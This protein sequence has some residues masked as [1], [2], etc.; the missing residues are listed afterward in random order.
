MLTFSL[1]TVVSPELRNL[2]TDVS[3]AL[4][5]NFVTEVS[6]ADSRNFVT[7]RSFTR[8]SAR[9]AETKPVKNVET[10]F[11]QVRGNVHSSII[12]LLLP[13]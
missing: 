3:F 9:A 8:K 11:L 4:S 6:F 7:A 13:G 1:E 2:V 12:F 10:I 5:I